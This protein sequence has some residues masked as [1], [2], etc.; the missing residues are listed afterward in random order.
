MRYLNKEK[1]EWVI[2]ITEVFTWDDN[3][4]EIILDDCV[5]MRHNSTIAMFIHH[6]KVYKL[7]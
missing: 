1:L 7:S 4:N 2:S 3:D 5:H 6:V